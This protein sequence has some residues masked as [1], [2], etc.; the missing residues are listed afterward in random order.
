MLT[1]QCVRLGT[2][3]LAAT[4]KK[5]IQQLHRCLSSPHKAPAQRFP[6]QATRGLRVAA[7]AAA[8]PLE[9][10]QQPMQQQQPQQQQ[11]IAGQVQQFESSVQE[12][13][14]LLEAGIGPLS[15]QPMVSWPCQAV[16]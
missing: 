1:T 5:C 10:Q 15:T 7:A 4:S 12:T 8:G 16:L 2:A 14:R 6:A 11:P 9:Q 3:S 13:L